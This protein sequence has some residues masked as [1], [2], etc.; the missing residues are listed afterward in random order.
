MPA[1][2]QPIPIPATTAVIRTSDRGSFKGCRRRWSLSSHLS[3]NLEPVQLASP[4]WFGTGIHYAFEDHFSGKFRQYDTITDAFQAYVN[5]TLK[6]GRS[7][8]PDDWKELTEMGHGMLEYYYKYWTIGR[9]PLTTF[10]VDGIPQVEINFLVDLPFNPQDLYPDSPYDKVV[11]SGTIDRITIDELGLLWL[12]DYKTAKT[13]KVSHFANDPQVTAY[14]WAASHLYDRPIG[15]MIYW[16]LLK[17]APTPPEPLVSGK[18]STN[19][20]QRTSR[21]MYKEALQ[22]AYGSLEGSP[23]ENVDFLNRL[24]MQEDE[25]QD[26]YIRRD[27]IFKNQAS[28][29]AEGAKILLELEDMLNPNLPMYPNV[30]FLCPAMCPF[31]EVCVSIDDGSEWEEQLTAETQQRAEKDTSWRSFLEP[32]NHETPVKDFA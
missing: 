14:C 12:V 4:L 15:G 30:T 8:L 11:Y 1:Q 21:V 5:A 25:N 28:L 6:Q 27:T 7:H 32:I 19:K 31:Y 18:I 20:N 17:Q 24:A 13:L 26:P 10:E 3:R 23:P 29:E 9:D 2:N 22:L 16:Q